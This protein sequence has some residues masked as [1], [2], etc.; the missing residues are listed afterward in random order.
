MTLRRYTVDK[1]F[2]LAG[3][4]WVGRSNYCFCGVGR[5]R[6]RPSNV[7]AP[8]PIWLPTPARFTRGPGLGLNGDEGEI[9]GAFDASSEPH[10]RRRSFLVDRH[11]GGA[12]AQ[13]SATEQQRL[14]EPMVRQPRNYEAT[15]AFVK[16]ATEHGDYEAAIG[17]LERL[18]FYSP[19]LSLV[20]YQLGSLYFR[21]R[22]YA[23]AKR[24]FIDALATP[25]LD[26]ATK[27]RIEASTSDHEQAIRAEPF[28]GL[29]PDR[30]ALPVECKLCAFEQRRSIE[31]H[32]FRLPATNGAKSDTNWFE[33]FGLSHDYHLQDERGTV[34]ET[35]FFGYLTQQFHL[36]DLDVGLFDVSFGPRLSFPP[37][38]C[39]ERPSSPM[40]SAATAGWTRRHPR[41]RRWRRL[42]RHPDRLGGRSSRTSNGGR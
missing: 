33:L 42:I 8:S 40:W 25:G 21:L 9:R 22:S 32:R 39:R 37:N 6:R 41:S 27:A 20:K 12:R 35:R 23:L 10:H 16:L 28:F 2:S 1:L 5:R 24:Y 36:H 34:L 7:L 19:D 29:R 3:Q 18:L 4:G 30:F 31:R 26:A 38:G 11:A 13:D 15:F 14:Y 17:A